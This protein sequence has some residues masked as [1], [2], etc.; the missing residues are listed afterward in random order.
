MV[1]RVFPVGYN[2]S[3]LTANRSEMLKCN[4]FRIIG[5]LFQKF[6]SH[7]NVLTINAIDKLIELISNDGLHII[8]STEL[9]RDVGERSL[10]FPRSQLRYLD[11]HAVSS[12]KS[13]GKFVD[14]S[15]E[16]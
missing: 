5:F 11:W 10:F 13:T 8:I 2:S 12:T 16:K 1:T 4:G 3:L 9:R 6:Y 15:R 7:M 14:D